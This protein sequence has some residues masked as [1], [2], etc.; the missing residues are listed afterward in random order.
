ME[1]K[2]VVIDTNLIFFLKHCV[3][4]VLLY[5]TRQHLYPEL[6]EFRFKDTAS[7]G[8]ES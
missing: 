5:S 7:M 6:S 8:S 4:S 3:D 1:E 2:E